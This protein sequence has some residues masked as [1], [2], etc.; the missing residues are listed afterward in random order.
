MYDVANMELSAQYSQVSSLDIPE[1]KFYQEANTAISGSEA[2]Y[3]IP[4][5][6]NATKGED[7]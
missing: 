1:G 2:P 7:D 4:A 5:P 6:L 3:E